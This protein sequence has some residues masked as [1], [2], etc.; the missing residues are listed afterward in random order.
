L[1]SLLRN[2]AT[3]EAI[4]NFLRD[5]A[6]KKEA[7]HHIGESDFVQPQRTMSCIGG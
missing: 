3:D 5:V 2:G 7:R 1:R 4:S 6:W